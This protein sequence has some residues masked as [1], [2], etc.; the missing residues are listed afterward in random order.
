VEEFRPSDWP[1]KKN[2]FLANHRDGIRPKKRKKY[3]QA[4]RFPDQTPL[5]LY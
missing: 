3:L 5:P 1:E 4:T 2:I